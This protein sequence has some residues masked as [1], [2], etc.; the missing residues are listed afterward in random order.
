[1]GHIR[2]G[3]IKRFQEH[4]GLEPTCGQRLELLQ[5]MQQKAFELIRILELEMSG[6]RDGDGKWSGCDPVFETIIEL[7][8]L[9]HERQE[10]TNDMPAVSEEFRD[11]RGNA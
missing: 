9:E 1:M 4:A 5:R 11:T 3:A 2:D 8:T 6:I 7:G 10:T